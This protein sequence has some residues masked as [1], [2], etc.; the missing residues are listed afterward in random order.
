MS[1][2]IGTLFIISAPS[3]AGKTSLVNALIE[4][5]KDICVSVSHTTR[6]QRP[7]E[8]DG[9]NY[10]FVSVEQFQQ[11]L[12]QS[13][14]LES[15]NVFGNY[16]GTSQQWVEQKLA[17]GIDVIL[18]IDWQGAQQV[19]ELL[20]DAMSIFI[21]P[22]SKAA[23]QD[24]LEKRGQDNEGVINKRMAAAVDEM[25]HHVE[26]DYLVVN[27][28]FDQALQQLQAIVI[29]SR[30]QLTKQQMRHQQLLTE[31]LS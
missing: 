21:L 29:A 20:P 9:V 17:N 3:G 24:R 16:Y 6:S 8:Q 27:D 19:R 7:G 11:M 1:K 18:E 4:K 13:A 30:Q 14:F 15:A 12:N 10:H 26:Y 22:P 5:T 25:T 23:L 28:D 2:S 31:L